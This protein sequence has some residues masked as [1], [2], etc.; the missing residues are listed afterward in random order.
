MDPPSSSSY[1][2]H[3]LGCIVGAPK[4]AIRLMF[5][6]GT[7][8]YNLVNKANVM[9]NFSSYVYFFPLHVAGNYVHII[10]RNNYVY[11]TLR[12]CHSV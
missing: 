10:R 8:L 7:S 2:P 9:H 3:S 11:A 6:E 12:V 4:I 1:G 5:F